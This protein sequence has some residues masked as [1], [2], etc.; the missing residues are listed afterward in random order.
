M[1]GNFGESYPAGYEQLA[2][3]NNAHTDYKLILLTCQISLSDGTLPRALMIVYRSYLSR[4]ESHGSTR[5]YIPRYIPRYI[6]GMYGLR[7]MR[8]AESP[9]GASPT[10][11]PPLP[12]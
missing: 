4:A 1:E 3:F 7:F 10:G 8:T 2:I 11:S 5:V 9:Y 6:Q 12:G